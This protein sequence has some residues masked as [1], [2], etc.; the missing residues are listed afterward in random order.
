MEYK[1]E[2]H[3]NIEWTGTPEIAVIVLED[4]RLELIK[5]HQEAIKAHGFSCVRI[6]GFRVTSSSLQ[7]YGEGENGEDV[8]KEYDHEAGDIT[9]YGPDLVIFSDRFRFRWTNKWDES[10]EI[11]TDPFKL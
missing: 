10:Q 7:V 8:L 9:Y 11:W 2:L 5:S 6:D 3:T 4:D 1:S